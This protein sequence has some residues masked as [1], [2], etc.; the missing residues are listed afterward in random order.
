MEFMNVVR[1]SQSE[2]FKNGVMPKLM[3][4]IFDLHAWLHKQTAAYALHTWHG[5]LSL[6]FIMYHCLYSPPPP[7]NYRIVCQCDWKES[8]LLNSLGI[9]VLCS[10]LRNHLWKRSWK[11]GYLTHHTHTHTCT[12]ITHTCMINTSCI[13][14]Y[15]IVALRVCGDTILTHWLYLLYIFAHKLIMQYMLALYMYPRIH[16]CTLKDT[17]IYHYN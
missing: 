16:V 14:T 5:L 3:Q 2:G 9:L 10:L 4:V 8:I 15:A 12:H 6:F 17:L 11:I 13:Y 7:P 1:L